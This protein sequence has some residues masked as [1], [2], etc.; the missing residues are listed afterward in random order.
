MKKLLSPVKYIDINKG[1][2]FSDSLFYRRSS[3]ISNGYTYYDLIYRKENI[4]HIP[5]KG[6]KHCDCWGSC[7]SVMSISGRYFLS[8]AGSFVHTIAH[9]H[10]GEYDNS[11]NIFG[12]NQG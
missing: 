7:I 10:K 3:V 11:F 12:L 9:S 4:I 2:S 1:T 5:Q 8:I 6:F